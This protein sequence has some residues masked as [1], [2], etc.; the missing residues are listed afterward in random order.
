MKLSSMFLFLFITGVLLHPLIL[1]D[2]VPFLKTFLYSLTMFI[3]IFL[4]IYEYRCPQ[5]PEEG[6]RAPGAGITSSCEPAGVQ[7]RTENSL[8]EHS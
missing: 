6:V 4:C 5:R 7:T 2:L 3:Y 8:E 1:D